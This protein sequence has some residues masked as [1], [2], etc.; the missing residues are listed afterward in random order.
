M[1]TSGAPASRTY[2]SIIFHRSLLLK[3]A[4]CFYYQSVSAFL[5]PENYIIVADC[6]R[7]VFKPQTLYAVS[8]LEGYPVEFPWSRYVNQNHNTLY[9]GI[10]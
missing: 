5:L 10:K 7:C 8:P 2:S 9:I 6:T 1:K 4:N 3:N